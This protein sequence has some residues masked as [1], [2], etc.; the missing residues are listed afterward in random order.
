MELEFAAADGF[1][2]AVDSVKV[3]R[4]ELAVNSSLAAAASF[5]EPEDSSLP[6]FAVEA[7]ADSDSY[8][9]QVLV[10]V[11]FAVVAAV[12]DATEAS[13]DSVVAFGLASVAVETDRELAGVDYDSKESRLLDGNCFE[14]QKA[15]DNCSSAEDADRAFLAPCL[16][17]QSCWPV[18]FVDSCPDMAL[19]YYTLDRRPVARTCSSLA[20]HD[21]FHASNC[22]TC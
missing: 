1:G 2:N 4:W 17:A 5:P 11:E 10:G 12:A 16:V 20:V 19:D 3:V 21:Q 6:D 14:R 8:H 22:D 13:F 9:C 7:V 18:A 15:L